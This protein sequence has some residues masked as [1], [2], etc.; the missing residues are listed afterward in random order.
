MFTLNCVVR[1]QNP[2]NCQ[3]TWPAPPF[4]KDPTPPHPSHPQRGPTNVKH[5]KGNVYPSL[6]CWCPLPD[7]THHALKSLCRVLVRAHAAVPEPLVGGGLRLT[8][9]PFK[10]INLGK[11]R[12][13]KRGEKNEKKRWER[14]GSRGDKS[15]FGHHSSTK[16]ID[17]KHQC[18]PVGFRKSSA[19]RAMIRHCNW[20]WGFNTRARA[21]TH[22]ACTRTYTQAASEA[23]RERGRE[24]GR[25][26][27][28][29]THFFP[30]AL[31]DVR[32][33]PLALNIQHALIRSLPCRTPLVAHA[34][35]GFI[36]RCWDDQEPCYFNFFSREAMRL[37]R[38][39]SS[40]RGN[41]AWE[42]LTWRAVTNHR[43]GY[44]PWLD[45]PLE[46]MPPSRSLRKLPLLSI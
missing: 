26:A 45:I 34:R 2:H 32:S 15:E 39:A 5:T 33:P 43:L 14:K 38:S 36:W 4:P 31:A 23:M 16:A 30:R 28:K 9:R 11:K 17:S 3:L 13:K 18:K 35:P 22:T 1:V 27:V 41:S 19:K 24:K 40:C 25:G 42:M 6:P 29:K 12:R 8:L 7:I 37:C 44:F 20:R 21:H 10:T 46:S